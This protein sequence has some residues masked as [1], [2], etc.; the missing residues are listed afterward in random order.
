M[1]AFRL[2][3]ARGG[4]GGGEKKNQPCPRKLQRANGLLLASLISSKLSG[5]PVQ[6]S[7]P[8]TSKT[9][10]AMF[11]T[12]KHLGLLNGTSSCPNYSH[13]IAPTERR[14]SVTDRRL[15]RGSQRAAHLF[16]LAFVSF[17][18][19]FTLLISAKVL[20]LC[21]ALTRKQKT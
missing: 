10:Q 4:C 20:P 21:S 1:V 6:A 2:W 14:D 12:T 8:D 5:E 16:C 9:K 15:H 11:T 19:A 17:P 13:S 3:G 7:E 18:V